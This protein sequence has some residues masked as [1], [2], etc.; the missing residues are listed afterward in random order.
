[1]KKIEILLIAFLIS[2]CTITIG[3][4]KKYPS[5]K[6]NYTYHIVRKGENLFRISKYYYDGKTV[7]EIKRG[8]ERIRKANKMKDYNIK[9]GQ[10]LLIPYT[11][12]H[13]PP[14]PLLPPASDEKVNDKKIPVKKEPIIKDFIWPA[15]GKIICDFG[16]L[17]NKGIDLLVKPGS[18]VYAVMDGEVVCVA[19]TQKYGETL[20]IKHKNNIFTVY[21]HD[22]NIN[23]KEG[24]KVKK[25]QI[26]GKIKRGRK[27]RYLHF[28]IRESG[29]PVD[30]FYYLPKKE[31]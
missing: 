21:A 13:Q 25:G 4:K 14:Y 16:E 29:E 3:P 22:I 6:R 11:S 5:K 23:V 1:M 12:K 30:P 2:G 20:I 10:K 15:D 7:E 28:E 17:G 9:V 8:I 24:E 26:V 27:K 31:K 19:F 18:E